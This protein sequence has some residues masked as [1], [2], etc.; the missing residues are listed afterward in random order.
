[1]KLF[2]KMITFVIKEPTIKNNGYEENYFASNILI[3]TYGNN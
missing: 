2:T 3:W 1:M